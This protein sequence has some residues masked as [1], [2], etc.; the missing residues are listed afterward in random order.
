V[1]ATTNLLAAL[2]LDDKNDV[3]RGSH[4]FYVIWLLVWKVRRRKK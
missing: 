3:R 4:L 1:V 2:V